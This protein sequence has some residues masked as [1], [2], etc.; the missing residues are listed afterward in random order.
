MP[1][2]IEI[3]LSQ[4][5]YYELLRADTHTNEYTQAIADDIAKN[6]IRKPLIV[7]PV[8]DMYEVVFGLARWKGALIAGLS[9]VPA[10][11]RQLTD[12]EA[13]E[14]AISDNWM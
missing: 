4:L 5:K 7:R 14:L 2:I 9:T 3:K 8:G 6:G 12:Q 10:E 1:Q 11:E 13:A